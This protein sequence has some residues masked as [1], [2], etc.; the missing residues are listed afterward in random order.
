M[1]EWTACRRF[2]APIWDGGEGGIILLDCVQHAPDQGFARRL[3][4]SRAGRSNSPRRNPHSSDL[5]EVIGNVSREMRFSW[6]VAV[7]EGLSCRHWADRLHTNGFAHRARA[8]ARGGQ[9]LL[10]GSHPSETCEVSRWSTGKLSVRL[11]LAVREGF[12]PSE[13]LT[14]VSPSFVSSS[15]ASSTE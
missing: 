10:S 7:R 5:R 4:R 9:T 8:C 14:L 12:E 13:Q 1:S 2:E 11:M 3:T 15:R 6:H